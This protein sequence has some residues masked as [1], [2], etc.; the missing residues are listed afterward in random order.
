[1]L[2]SAEK[3]NTASSGNTKKRE[4]ERDRPDGINVEC[5]VEV[6]KVGNVSPPQVDTSGKALYKSREV[7]FNLAPDENFTRLPF[8]CGIVP[9]SPL[10]PTC[11]WL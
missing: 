7:I 4:F 11:R 10:S 5:S 1:M 3:Q 2:S 6:R 8:V 9:P